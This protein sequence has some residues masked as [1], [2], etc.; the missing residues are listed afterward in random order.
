MDITVEG[1]YIPKTL[2]ECYVNVPYHYVRTAA[3]T[4]TDLMLEQVGPTSISVSWTPPVAG[5]VTLTGYSI[6]YNLVPNGVLTVEAA[7]VDATSHPL[8]GLER[9]ATYAVAIMALSEQLP[10]PLSAVVE[11]TLSKWLKTKNMLTL[12]LNRLCT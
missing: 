9:G 5:G 6:V 12:F 7:E 11:L 1:T 10:S 2:C 3:S 4:P 8:N